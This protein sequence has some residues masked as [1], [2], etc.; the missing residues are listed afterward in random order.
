MSE[1]TF[2]NQ[3]TM[4]RKAADRQLTII[5]ATDPAE[6]WGCPANP[7]QDTAKVTQVRRWRD[8]TTNG[9][10]VTIAPVFAYSK[11]NRKRMSD[12]VF[13][14]TGIRVEVEER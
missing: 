10:T 1:Q 5:L 7:F 6:C 3:I 4:V 8:E 13:R 2:L 14:A 11:E 12:G 9:W